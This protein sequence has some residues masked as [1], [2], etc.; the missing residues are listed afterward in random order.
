MASSSVNSN[1]VTMAILALAAW[2]ILTPFAIADTSP[3]DANGAA[4]TRNSENSL[5]L[6][7]AAQV[8]AQLTPMVPAGMR[9]DR[10]ELGCKPAAG[11]EL[12]AVAPGLSQLTSR[13]F[14]VELEKGGRS[15]YCSATMDASR[16]MLVAIRDIQPNEPVTNADF[17]LRWV[18]AFGASTGAL[19]EFPNQGP[20]AS[21][22]AIRAGQPLYQNALLRPIAVRP[23]EMVTV[24]VKN[25]P[26]KVRAQL[27]A[28]TQG[29]VGDSVT[30]VNPASGTPVVVMVTGPHSAELV[31]Q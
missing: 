15:T 31:L 2:L 23:G 11:S 29:A 6:E 8:Q 4:G 9:V 26:V 5:A 17:E 19:L 13:T 22:I 28:Q 30:L 12:E 1:R 20:Y 10:I 21:A 24:T 3:A 7:L 14:M 27:Q 18:D 16:Q 25:G